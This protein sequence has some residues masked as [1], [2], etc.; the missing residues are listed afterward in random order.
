MMMS[1]MCVRVCSSHLPCRRRLVRR[2]TPSLALRCAAFSGR[3]AFPRRTAAL[4]SA[5][6]AAI[7]PSQRPKR[8]SQQEKERREKTPETVQRDCACLCVCV[9]V[10]VCL[11]LSVYLC[12]CVCVCVSVCVYVWVEESA[13]ERN[14][15]ERNGGKKCNVFR[16]S[17]SL[18]LP[19]SFSSFP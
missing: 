12:V 3:A 7:R 6:R 10:C 15:R 16:L 2:Q 1:M 11:C 8:E 17:L 19:Y 5:A 9:C 4:S 18:F 14:E 13:V